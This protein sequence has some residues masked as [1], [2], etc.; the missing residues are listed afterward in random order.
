VPARVAAAV[1]VSGGH[2]GGGAAAAA[3]VGTPRWWLRGLEVGGVVGGGG[4][5]GCYGGACRRWVAD[6]I[7]RDTRRHFWGSPEKFAEKLFR[8][9]RSW[10]WPATA[11]W[12]PAA[13]AGFGGERDKVFN[14]ETAKYGKIWYDEDV[15][16]LRSVETEFPAIVFNDNLTSDEKLSCEPT[17]KVKQEKDKIRTKPDKNEKRGKAQQCQSPI[18]V[19]KAEQEKK[20][21]FQGTKDANPRSCV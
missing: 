3:M 15:H 18:T 20:M 14:W 13:A 10:W 21:Q 9:R 8:R 16:D 7:D 2:G 11:S 5:G 4:S 6:L 1:G 12:W 17:V 19:K